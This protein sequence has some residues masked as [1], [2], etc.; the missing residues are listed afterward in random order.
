MLFVPEA[1]NDGK[2]VS[3]AWEASPN[4]LQCPEVLQ[5][6]N[7]LGVVFF[8]SSDIFSLL[9]LSLDFCS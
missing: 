8:L 3:G 9:Y 6:S 4:C 7:D 1:D 2:R 5:L